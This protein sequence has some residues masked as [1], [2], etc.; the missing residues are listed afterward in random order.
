M[1]RDFATLALK[2]YKELQLYKEA[3]NLHIGFLV[4]AKSR[5]EKRYKIV[6]GLAKCENK[7][8]LR[9]CLLD[10]IVWVGGQSWQKTQQKRN[11]LP[12]KSVV[13]PDVVTFVDFKIV[14]LQTNF[15]CGSL[16][17]LVM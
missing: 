11:F 8:A 3:D 16:Q 12:L 1:K 10:G 15:R 9:T 14:S 17:M 4:R 6:C 5:T 13:N 2:H 7:I